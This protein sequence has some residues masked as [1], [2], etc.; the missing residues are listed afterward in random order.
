VAVALAL[1][2]TTWTSIKYIGTTYLAVLGIAFVFAGAL[3]L[4]HVIAS[5]NMGM[6]ASWDESAQLWIAARSVETSALLIVA[7][8]PDRRFRAGWLLAAYAAATLLLTLSILYW[9]VFPVSYRDDT[10]LTPFKKA[11]ECV[12][13]LLL[14]VSLYLL[15]RGRRKFDGQVFGF[16]FGSVAAAIGSEL[17]FALFLSRV[18]L[19]NQVGHYLKVVSFYLIYKAIVQTGIRQPYALVFRGLQE[20]E[21]RLRAELAERRRI[22][23]E[24]AS[25]ARF[26]AENPDPVLR[27]AAGGKL[28]YA[29]KA[30]AA[31]LA[32]LSPDSPAGRLPRPLAGICAAAL[33]KNQHQV[34]ELAAGGE[35]YLVDAVPMGGEGYVNVY[36]RIITERKRAEEALRASEERFRGIVTEAPVPVLVFAEDGEVLAVSD[37]LLRLTGYRREELATLE[38]WLQ[39]AYGPDRAQ[40]DGIRTSLREFLATGRLFSNPERNIRTRSGETRVW[41]FSTATPRRLPD[42]RVFTTSMAIDVTGRKQFE[43]ELQRAKEAAEAANR[44]KSEFLAHMSHEIR[45]PISG[46]LGMI[47]LLASRIQDPQQRAYLEMMREAAQ[48]LLSIVR[49]VLDLSRIE[50]GKVELQAEEIVLVEELEKIQSPFAVAAAGKGLSFDRIVPPGLPARVRGDRDRLGQVLRNLLSNALKYTDRGG[51]RLAVARQEEGPAGALQKPQASSFRAE[52]G[53]SARQSRAGQ[54]SCLAAL[55]E[56]DVPREPRMAEAREGRSVDA[57]HGGR[58]GVD[59]GAAPAE[60][61]TLRFEVRDTGIGIPKDRQHLLFQSFSRVQGPVTRKTVDGTGLGLVISKRLV[62]MMGGRIWVESESGRG[63][64]FA[65]TVP[66]EPCRIETPGGERLSAATLA[67][68]PPLRILV[69]EDDRINRT[70][71]EVTLRD[72]GHRVTLVTDGLEAVEE[73]QRRTGP[74]P[75]FD[76]VL[77]D[78][79]LPQMDGLEA[80]RRIRELERRAPDEGRLPVIALTAFAMKEDEQRLRAGGMDGYVTKPVDLWKLAEEIRRLLP[81]TS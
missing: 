29:N 28:L 41:Q 4:L 10:G 21:R 56:G 1:F 46:V 35:V 11:A 76:V 20:R 69:A 12:I 67:A 5:S 62:E 23:Q 61:I 48:S 8:F 78:M 13:C 2:M 38:D 14:L 33:Q 47:E 30:A 50:S 54:E 70:F 73:V 36:A 25:V 16:L 63:S 75:A 51:I 58:S 77:M 72:A 68:L 57:S 55:Q 31:F 9:D 17:M 44:A 59:A 43:E 15:Y 80:T 32:G 65:F 37:T 53:A 60:R 3:D 22:E 74:E 49:D 39:R 27:V 81:P 52:R 71:L 6:F 79:Q 18:D 7:A 24:I 19:L 40:L 42:G 34:E 26:P 45:T 64:V 66:F